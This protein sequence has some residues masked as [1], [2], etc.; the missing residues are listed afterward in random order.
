MKRLVVCTLT[1]CGDFHHSEGR[2][3]EYDE[4]KSGTILPRSLRGLESALIIHAALIPIV[5]AKF[6]KYKRL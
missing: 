3:P 5:T 2:N 6:G 1:S 4:D